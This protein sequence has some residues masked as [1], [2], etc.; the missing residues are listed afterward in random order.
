MHI[1][2]D[3]VGH[4]LLGNYIIFEESVDKQLPNRDYDVFL[5]AGQHIP[6][7]AWKHMKYKPKVSHDLIV[8]PK[9]PFFTQANQ[10][11][12]RNQTYRIRILNGMFDA[13]FENLRFK[14]D[15]VIIPGQ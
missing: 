6:K 2:Q 7:K 4:G 3:N 14:T 5:L 8:N 12:Q 9:V 11:F 13:I 15:C 1:T 10:V